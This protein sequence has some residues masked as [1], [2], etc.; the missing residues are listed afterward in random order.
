MDQTPLAFEFLSGQTYEATGLKTVWVKGGMGGWDKRQATLHITIFAD[1][2]MR[3]EPRISCKG[4]GTGANILR[5]MQ[6]YDPRV[7]VKFN[8]TG[9]ANSDNMVQ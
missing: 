1:S 2:E 3:L 8:P 7:G 5:E 4:K 9:Y 6:L